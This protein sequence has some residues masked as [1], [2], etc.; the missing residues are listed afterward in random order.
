MN[1]LAAFALATIVQ[2]SAGAKAELPDKANPVRS[3]AS[4]IVTLGSSATEIAFA[5][6]VGAKV[7][8]VDLSSTY[9][10]AARGL[11]KVGYYRAVGAEGILSLGPD[12]VLGTDDAGPATAIDQLRLAQLDVRLVPAGYTVEAAKA[13]VMGIAAV[14]GLEEKGREIVLSMEADLARAAR[15]A[16]AS[17]KKPKVLFIYARG[18]GT[19]SVSGTGTAA[20]GIIALAGGRN[21]VDGYEGYK[22]LTAEALVGA[23]PEIILMTKA[24]LDGL[25]GKE[26]LLKQPGVSMTPAGKVG[27][28]VVLDDELLLSFGPRLGLA[29]LELGQLF[30]DALHR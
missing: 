20:A 1:I 29:S 4:R 28:I 13:K 11:P 25:G 3:S 9:P 15:A 7:V 10:P 2:I 18:Q 17:G 8:A 14:L 5:L 27:R 16:E 12:L 30:R 24:G 22:P 21:A 6:G 19:L 23:S 26:G